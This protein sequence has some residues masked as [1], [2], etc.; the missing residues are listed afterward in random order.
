MVPMTV[1][2][3]RNSPLEVTAYD[4]G[5]RFKANQDPY[6][7]EEEVCRELERFL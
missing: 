2:R 6:A 1:I 5:A 3:Y 4:H 7:V